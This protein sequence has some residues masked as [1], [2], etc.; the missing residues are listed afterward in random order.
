M[1]PLQEY[2]QRGAALIIGLVFL[3]LLAVIGLSSMRNVTLQERIT[4]NNLDS[5]RAHHNADIALLSAE[6]VV[7]Q[8]GF[9]TTNPY[10]NTQN[11]GVSHAVSTLWDNC[12]D[13]AVA[14]DNLCE[15]LASGARVKYE[16]TVQNDIYQITVWA[17]GSAAANVML[18]SVYQGKLIE[19]Q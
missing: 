15:V 11:D 1:I 17:S 3:V 18:Q 12:D 16:T 9:D 19:Q 4:G 5:Y 14:D 13:A 2:Q 8:A 10:L 7:S 6:E